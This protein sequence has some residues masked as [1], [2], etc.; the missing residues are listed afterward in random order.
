M[1][2]SLD[3]GWVLSRLMQNAERALQ[4]E[5][6]RGPDGPVIEYRY[7][8]AVANKSL[9]LLGREI[10]MFIE[11]HE[12]GAVGDFD[13]MSDDE[14]RALAGLVIEHCPPGK[15]VNDP[16]LGQGVVEGLD[17]DRYANGL[18]P[19]N[20]GG[21]NLTLTLV[22]VPD[23]PMKK[24]KRPKPACTAAATIFERCRSARFASKAKKLVVQKSPMS[25][26]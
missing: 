11:R 13:R 26:A 18:L 8:G 9:E 21:N 15:P 5:A 16:S 6:V 20:S 17:Q 25:K 19:V 2:C 24:P 3:T 22:S 4:N 14:L 7:N 10:G 23:I 12:V 1:E